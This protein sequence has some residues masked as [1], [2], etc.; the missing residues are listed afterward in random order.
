MAVIVSQ[1]KLT[2]TNVVKLRFAGSLAQCGVLALFTA[3]AAVAAWFHEPWSDEAQAWLISRDLGISGILHQMGY[4]GSPPLW[5]LLLWALTRLQVPYAALGAVS[6]AL[7][8]CGMYIWLQKSP[9]P[10]PVRFLVPFAFYYQYQYAVVA[11]S[12]AL[13][14]LLAFAAAAIWSAKP[15]R[16]IPLA[17]VLALLMQTNMHGFMIA[18]GITCAVAWEWIREFWNG[19]LR[20]TQVWEMCAGAVLVLASA[21]IAKALASPYPDCSFKAAVQLRKGTR[22]ETITS[23]LD[24]L[25]GF[26]KAVGLNPSWAVSLVLICAMWVVAIRKGKVRYSLIGTFLLLAY[27]I[28]MEKVPFGVLQC[29]VVVVLVL[30]WFIAVRGLACAF[31]FLFTVLAM[32]F[33]WSRPWHYGMALTAFLVSVWAAWRRA[34]SPK[35]ESPKVVLAVSL[36]VLVILQIP[37]TAKTIYAEIKSPYSGARATAEFLDAH[38]GHRRIYCTNFYGTGVQAYFTKNIFTNWP[39]SYWT[40]SNQS[41]FEARFSVKHALPTNALVVVPAG[42]LSSP[43]SGRSDTAGTSLASH[44]FHRTKEFCGA[45][46]W[47]GQV[48]EYEC[49]DIYEKKR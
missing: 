24:G 37:S 4:E 48:S 22:F 19:R 43:K 41:A 27:P 16:V 18:I 40:W 21:A 2:D 15:V 9:L 36:A 35:F 32:G 34:D 39:N 10:A 38:V 42:G 5:H 45:Q 11:R 3:I 14:T 33:V 25:A 20:G 13:S 1:E 28:H 29:L 44:Q 49:Y 31:P 30:S 23:A 46:F 6:V 7:V 17:V 8:A 26:S 12:Y 47:L